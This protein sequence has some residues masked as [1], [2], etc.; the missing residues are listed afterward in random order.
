MGSGHNFYQDRSPAFYIRQAGKHSEL[1]AELIAVIF[2]RAEVPEVQ[3]KRCD[4]LLS[5]QRKTDPAIF[6]QVCRY[7][8]DN[9]ILSYQSIKRVINNK[10]YLYDVEEEKRQ[11]GK[12]KNIQ[13]INIRG[14]KYYAGE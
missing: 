14:K 6:E 12:N 7:A 1:L 4:G 10:A 2:Q 9:D 8:L 3:Y 13:H 5:L 11:D